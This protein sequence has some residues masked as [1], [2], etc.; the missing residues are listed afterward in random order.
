MGKKASS[1]WKICPKVHVFVPFG[2]IWGIWTAYVYCRYLP[3]YQLILMD[4]RDH[5][6][7]QRQVKNNFANWNKRLHQQQHNQTKS[8]RNSKING[9]ATTPRNTKESGNKGRDWYGELEKIKEQQQHSSDDQNFHLVI[10]HCDQ[11]I[12]WIWKQFE[13]K[14]GQDTKHKL[15]TV[16][17]LSK[18][19][20]TLT[21]IP[22]EK[23]LPSFRNSNHA[24]LF[25]GLR[26]YEIVDLPNVGRCDHS[27]AYWITHVLWEQHKARHM[28]KKDMQFLY[29]KDTL[30]EISTHQYVYSADSGRAMG[31]TFSRI[32]SSVHPS[33]A[34]LFVKD[35]DNTYRGAQIDD[36]IQ[37]TT[38]LDRLATSISNSTSSSTGDNVAATKYSQLKDSAFARPIT[39][40]IFCQSYPNSNH[41]PTRKKR[42]LHKMTN[43]A[44]RS[45]LWTFHLDKYNRT[46][47]KESND[48]GFLSQHR[49][50]GEWISH[51]EKNYGTNTEAI[52]SRDYRNDILR[53]IVRP[54]NTPITKD[55]SN[56]FYYRHSKGLPLLVD[57]A[58]GY[59]TKDYIVQD[60]VPVCYGGVFGTHWGQLSSE[61]A[62]LTPYGWKAV[63]QSLGRADNLEE[64]HYM[65][66][67]WGDLLSWSNYTTN[68]QARDAMENARGL[69]LS[70][71]ELQLLLQ[72]KL[73]H[74]PSE[75]PY[76]GMVILDGVK[77]ADQGV[78]IVYDD[79]PRKPQ[80]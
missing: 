12:D 53:K 14:N 72:D 4:N 22:E 28:M 31:D 73:R 51:L 68:Y 49:P 8:D 40:G 21:V 3:E 42:K 25:A 55:L 36:S 57:D 23:D 61:D 66:R 48:G 17:I 54:K 47:S 52:F 62:P 63:V 13:I 43:L 58:K 44:H 5:E 6:G 29:D 11:P 50:M 7:Y 65:E 60:L 15:K 80:K 24:K 34:V 71:Y 38:V 74:M 27:Y 41:L 69:T 76:A 39:N 20:N 33:D 77:L 9:K 30:E 64:G 67:W 1:T 16:T 32:A 46:E 59:H 19:H 79:K 37:F 35:N 70:D 75:N 2:I 45:V 18:C 56:E 10:S 26:K 78:K